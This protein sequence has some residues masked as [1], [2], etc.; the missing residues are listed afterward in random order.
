[1]DQDKVL[2][3]ALFRMVKAVAAELSVLAQEIVGIGEALSGEHASG[4]NNACRNIQMFDLIAQGVDSHASL[5]MGLMDGNRAGA[6]PTIAELRSHIATIPFHSMR[7]RLLAAI[8]DTEIEQESSL[9]G[10]DV[11]F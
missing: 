11:W 5:L 10:T 2:D 6:R 8:G 9:P 7:R 1:M 3:D 4:A